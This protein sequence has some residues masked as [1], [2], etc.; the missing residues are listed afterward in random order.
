MINPTI[1]VVDDEIVGRKALESL[2]IG[3]GYTLLFAANGEEA[4]TQAIT[5]KP[6]L[7][8]LDVMMPGMDGYTVCRSLRDNPDVAEIPIIMITALDDHKSRL[9]GIEAGADDFITKPF[10]RAELRARIRTILRLNR[11]RRLYQ[12]N[13]QFNW[14]IEHAEDGYVRLNA[15]GDIVFLNTRAKLFLELPDEEET[16]LAQLNFLDT[17]RQ[18]YQC[19]PQMAWHGWPQPNGG[20]DLAQR[21]LVRPETAIMPAVWLAVTVLDWTGHGLTSTDSLIRL[22]DVT[23][24]VTNQ[25]DMRNFHSAV[26]HKL[27]TP[28]IYVVSS[29]ELLVDEKDG[30]TEDS[31]LAAIA[32]EGAYHLQTAVNDVLTYAQVASLARRG[33][34]LC[35]AQLGGLLEEMKMLFKLKGLVWHIPE[36]LHSI[37]LV[38][39]Q[40][41]MEVL[42]WELLENSQKFHPTHTPTVEIELSRPRPGFIHLAFRDDGLHLTPEQLRYVGTPYFQG[43]KHFTGQVPGMGLGLATA[44]ALLWQVGGD[45]RVT[46]RTNRSGLVIELNVPEKFSSL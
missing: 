2:L 26:S 31:G 15:Q 27:R 24:V 12:Q 11:Y 3:R 25:M 35:L 32:L 6:D 40:Q 22:R 1:L 8:L 42:L 37:E 13:I 28:L 39:S 16:P 10:N 43:E 45:I 41:G 21:Y 29:L 33:E 4:Y 14:V 30:N 18:Q 9:Q 5:H 19:V 46:N 23:S 44:A 17:I 7:I 38:L 36:P 20:Q 34:T